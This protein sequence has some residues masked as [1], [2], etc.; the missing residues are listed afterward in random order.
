MPILLTGGLPNDYREANGYSTEAA[1]RDGHREVNKQRTEAIVRMAFTEKRST[2][3][4]AN[5][6]SRDAE[7]C[8]CDVQSG[9]T[10]AEACSC[11]GEYDHLLYAYV[12]DMDQ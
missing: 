8:K 7:I 2:E 12:I 9:F 4:L 11:H 6:E 10:R 5:T 3:T 1:Y